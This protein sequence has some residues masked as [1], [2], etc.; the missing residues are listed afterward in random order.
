MKEAKK[1]TAFSGT[2]RQAAAVQST[3]HVN[4]SVHQ[5]KMEDGKS[6]YIA[7]KGCMYYSVYGEELSP[8]YAHAI[9]LKHCAFMR[10]AKMCL[11]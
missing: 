5:K 10:T 6:N 3:C 9:I 11:S 7:T 2:Y 4:K 8:H 1:M